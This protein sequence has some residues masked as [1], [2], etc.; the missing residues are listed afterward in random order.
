MPDLQGAC[1]SKLREGAKPFE[2]ELKAIKSREESVSWYPYGTMYN[3][4]HIAPLVV[5]IDHLFSG[6]RKFADIG[7][8]DGDLAFFLERNGNNCSIYDFG[9]TNYNGLKGARRVKELLNSGV[10]IHEVNLDAQFEMAGEYDLVFFLGILYHLKN[11]FYALE[12]I[13]KHSEHL[14]VS[15]RICRHFHQGAPDVSTSAAA[16]LLG[17]TESNNDSTNYWIF[18]EAGLKRIFERSGWEVVSFRT[19]GDVERSNPQDNQRDER[20]FAL[21]KRR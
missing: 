16:Y 2:E 7:A 12:K 13:A 8:A 4:D 15:T 1:F 6:D 20:A 5:G 9:P 14:L 21:L 17:P 3:F 19:L 18:T 11:P 10:D